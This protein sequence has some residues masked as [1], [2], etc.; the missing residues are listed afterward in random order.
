[1]YYSDGLDISNIDL[2]AFF[3]TEDIEDFPYDFSDIADDILDRLTASNYSTADQA[4]GRRAIPDT[5]T[6]LNGGI[7]RSDE[8]TLLEDSRIIL[9]E[10][11]EGEIKKTTPS[12][13]VNFTETRVPD[14]T[15]E[16]VS[17][18]GTL[19]YQCPDG[20]RKY[21][22]S[23]LHVL[24]HHANKGTPEHSCDCHEEFE[25]LSAIRLH[26]QRHSNTRN[27]T[28][29]FCSCQFSSG[30][31]MGCHISENHTVRDRF[32]CNQC[33]KTFH[34]RDNLTKHL[35]THS[36]ER[37]FPCGICTVAFKTS[38]ALRNHERGHADLRLHECNLCR[39]RFR[40][41]SALKLHKRSHS[42]E[43]PFHCQYCEKGFADRSTRTQHERTHTGEKPYRCILCYRQTATS[44]N[45]KTH[46]RRVHKITVTN[47]RKYSPR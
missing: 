30:R 31:A 36:N 11:C 5:S 45:L 21:V 33:E 24:K 34:A 41:Q 28:C 18:S 27:F 1:M 46:Y 4:I 38:S 7:A 37:P 26:L 42:G 13:A 2:T 29:H 44:S 9:H 19:H 6:D 17:T 40:D 20:Q 12:S 39:K 10:R 15:P 32:S 22:N 25:R 35:K 16:S 43:R 8:L 47:I 3:D 14:E 23:E